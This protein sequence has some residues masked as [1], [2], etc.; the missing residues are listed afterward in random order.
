[1][2]L[3]GP[4]DAVFL[5]TDGTI[6]GSLGGGVSVISDVAPL[7]G[8]STAMGGFMV[9]VPV[10]A[11]VLFSGIDGGGEAKGGFVEDTSGLCRLLV[12][13]PD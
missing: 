4:S 11:S 1:V 7:D 12:T 10:P 3:E 8:D 9:S 6:T 13:G 5:G 2:G